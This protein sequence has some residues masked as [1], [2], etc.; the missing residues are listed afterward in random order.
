MRDYHDLYL[1]TDILLLADV[2]EKF[3][4]DSLNMYNL[5]PVSYYTMLGLSWDAA[6]KPSG[7]ELQIINDIDMYQMVE[8]GIR[9]GISMITTRY[10]KANCPKMGD[11]YDANKPTTSLLYL[12]ANSLYPYAMCEPLPVDQFEWE[13]DD[14]DITQV[15]DDA[16]Y[17]YIL[18]FD[19]H[20]PVEKH[21]YFNDYPLAPEK[22]RVTLEM[23]SP[24]Q[25]EYF[26][27]EKGT[28]KLIPHLGDKTEYVVHYLSQFKTVHR[29]RNGK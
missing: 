9:G 2:F 4:N 21:S 6:L 22:K 11:M 14:I 1:L 8:S 25:Q 18:E 7:V 13:R 23:L 19:L 28:D 20:C 5:E 16:E 27:D 24:F 10:A 15:A 29:T 12:N 17:G 3:R 26:P